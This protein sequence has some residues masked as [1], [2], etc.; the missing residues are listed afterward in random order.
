MCFLANITEGS[1]LSFKDG[2][3]SDYE[4]E[5]YSYDEEEML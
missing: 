1:G 3:P 5:V 2:Q 4:I